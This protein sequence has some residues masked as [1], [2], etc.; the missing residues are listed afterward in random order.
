MLAADSCWT[1][2]SGSSAV[3]ASQK[4]TENGWLSA[5]QLLTMPG[6]RYL[7]VSRRYVSRWPD[8]APDSP[9]CQYHCSDRR[10]LSPGFARVSGFSMVV[11]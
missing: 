11:I 7:E 8:P 3:C 9:A 1:H 10:F 5:G 2:D 6:M 4:C